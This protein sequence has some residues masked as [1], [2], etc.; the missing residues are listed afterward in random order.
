MR[1]SSVERQIE[2]PQMALM[3][4]LKADPVLEDSEE[5][6]ALLRKRAKTDTIEMSDS[7]TNEP[8][9]MSESNDNQYVLGHENQDFLSVSQSE[10]RDDGVKILYIQMQYCEGEN[11]NTFLIENPEKKRTQTKW[12]IFKQICEAVNYLHNHGLIHRDIKPHNIFLDENKDARLG[13]FGLAIKYQPSKIEFENRSEQKDESP[14]L[15][16]L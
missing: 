10:E 5:D 1:T 6:S 3:K 12:K 8:S 9:N 14:K 15:R 13:D 2:K 16:K 7:K 11:L 4:A